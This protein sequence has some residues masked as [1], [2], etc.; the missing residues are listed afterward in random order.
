MLNG[1]ASWVL[2]AAFNPAGNRVVTGSADRTVRIWDAQTG[3]EVAPPKLHPVIVRSVA[4]SPDGHW[5]LT[6]VSSELATVS[7][8]FSSTQALV[9]HVKSLLPRCLSRAQRAQFFLDPEPPEWC[10]VGAA[11]G[12]R[13][14]AKSFKPLWPYHT[15]AWTRW[16]VDRQKGRP[17]AMPAEE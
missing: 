16:L 11:E 17:A 5:L 2:S 4:F 6:A 10:I 3:K 14:D 13:L 1:H 15:A 12:H 7:R 9:D 8:I